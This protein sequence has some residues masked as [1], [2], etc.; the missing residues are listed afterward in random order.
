MYHRDPVLPVYKLIKEV[1]PYRGNVNIGHEIQQDQIALTTAAKN[2][3][4]KREAQKK[5]HEHRPSKHKF[6]VGD[7][8]LLNKHNK[9]KHELNGN[10]TIEL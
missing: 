8:V 2:L 1:I 9:D 10:Q 3:Q 5:P 4:K 7:L 6:N